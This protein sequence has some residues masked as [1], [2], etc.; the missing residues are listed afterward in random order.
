[1]L[2]LKVLISTILRSYRIYSDVPENE[3]KLRG[4]IILKR[5]DGFNIKIEPRTRAN[6]GE[7]ASIGTE[8]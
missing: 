1:M 6:E 5:S 3:F 2:K 7:K 4:D 8:A